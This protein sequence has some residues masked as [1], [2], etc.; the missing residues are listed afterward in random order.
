V[1]GATL[2]VVAVVAGF[3]VFQSTRSGGE[4]QAL[5]LAFQ[6]G[7]SATYDIH[8]SMTG[9]IDADAFG[10]MPIDM[11]VSQT[12][13]WQI[14]AVDADGVATVEVTTDSMS[15]AVNGIP[16]PD[17]SGTV[18]PMT[19]RIAP[20]GR[21][22]TAGGLSFSSSAQTAGTGFPGMDQM[23]PLL[24]DHPVAPGDSWTKDFSQDFPFGAGTI[25]YT[26]KSIFDRYEDVNGVRAAVIVTT[27]TLPLDFSVDFGKLIDEMGGS[28]GDTSGSSDLEGLKH[29]S[30]TYG[31]QGTFAM[32]SWM[33]PATRTMLK[34]SSRGDF[35]MTIEF[36]GVPQLEGAMAITASFAQDVVA[37]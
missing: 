29:A 11:D 13:G 34:S 4:A 24:P 26:T 16:V 33:D 10:T 27:F 23:T 30:M 19:M 32:T 37:R 5:T 15:G 8:T 14:T 2:V 17:T 12:V 7:D 20:D 22:L 28:F 21:V 35:D 3:L 18:P 9:T 36:S 25:E 31:G 1:I 6:P